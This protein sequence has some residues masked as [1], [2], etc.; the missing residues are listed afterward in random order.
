MKATALLVLGTCLMAA[1]LVQ[2]KKE[3]VNA[4]QVSRALVEKPDSTVFSPFYDSTVVP[5]ADITP[6]RNDI[7]TTRGVLNIIRANCSSPS[8]HGGRIS[9]TLTNYT[10]IRALVTPGNP[11]SSRLF[12]LVTTKDLNKAMPPINY[13]VDLS[14]TDK[15][16]IYNWILHGALENPT[17]KDYLPAAVSLI[18]NGCASANCHNAATVGGEWAR[19]SLINI[20]P[21]DTVSFNLIN[22]STG[23]VTIYSQLREPA[24]SREWNLYK[25][26]VRKFYADTVLNASFRPYKTFNTPV[27][28]AN[29]RGPLNTYD[30]VI[31]DILYPKAIRS[32]STV[33]Y[34]NAAG[35]RFFV[36][37]DNLNST[38]SMLSRVDSTILLANPRTSVF[39]TRHQGDMA[40]A[41]GGLSPSEIAQIK[42]WYFLDPNVPD[43][44]KFGIGGAG[45][46]KY[47]KTGNIIRK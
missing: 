34:T 30:D 15:T 31:F 35:Q 40:F 46:F 16:K 8:C 13:G 44:W 10:Q 2:C 24:L 18:T 39:A 5:F 25:D 22:T 32:N 37:G 17:L 33:V 47:S 23:A 28:A 7:A 3:G 6:G 45:I 42:A 1:L 38:S 19:R 36:R 20:Q 12:E 29:R 14:V 4:S 26:S 11:E 41:D 27:I 21:T 43:V 9:P